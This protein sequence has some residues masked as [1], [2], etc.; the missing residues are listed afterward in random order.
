[1]RMTT[2]RPVPGPREGE[3]PVS[4]V[5]PASQARFALALAAGKAAATA[6]RVL[7]VGGGTSFPGAAARWIDPHVLE[8]A[9]AA[10]DA[11][12]VIVTGSNGKTTTCRMLAALARSSGL[13]VIQNRT[14]SNLLQGV[15]SAAVQATDLRG[16]MDAQLVRRSGW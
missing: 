14:G 5:S 7:R 11:S 10:T 9:V 3:A 1:M 12:K 2:S 15:I 4:P 13:K 8:K 16:R 6:S